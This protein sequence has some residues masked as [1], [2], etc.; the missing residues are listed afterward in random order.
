M[1]DLRDG[2][3]LPSARA[4]PLGA[5]ALLVRALRGLLACRRARRVSRARGFGALARLLPRDAA[6]RS[7]CIARRH[8]ERSYADTLPTHFHV[9]PCPRMRNGVQR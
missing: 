4:S 5:L 1:P 7:S 2:L 3:R 8:F 6:A 9:Q